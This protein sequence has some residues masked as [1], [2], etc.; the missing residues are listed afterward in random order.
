VK[1]TSS[2]NFEE[3]ILNC[4]PFYKY[5][6]RDAQRE[7]LKGIESAIQRR[8]KVIIIQAPTGVG[9][10]AISY[11]VMRYFDDGYV[12]TGTKALQEQY[13]TDFEALL[14]LKVEVIMTVW[15]AIN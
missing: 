7:L 5:D 9:K 8:K 15:T 2:G 10:S 13:L 1:Q 3:S 12:C 6:I 11:A 4:F 14:L